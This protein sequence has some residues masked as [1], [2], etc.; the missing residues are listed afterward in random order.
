M[1][2]LKGCSNAWVVT[3]K[4]VLTVV[5]LLSGL[6]AAPANAELQWVAR[7]ADVDVPVTSGRVDVDFVFTNLGAAPVAL[8]K[9]SASCSC[10]T[11]ALPK[12]VYQPGEKGTLSVSVL[13]DSRDGPESRKVLVQ[14]DAQDDGGTVLKINVR[15]PSIA[16][17]EPPVLEWRQG[18]PEYRVVLV[19]VLQKPCRV[20]RVKSPASQECELVTVKE[21]EVYRVFAK[22]PGSIPL[23]DVVL[24]TDCITD[25]G[26]SKAIR[27]QQTRAPSTAKR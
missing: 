16:T 12:R 8:K 19:R 15:S 21:G 24:D 3:M 10:V 11:T 1:A 27:I 2:G 7:E 17:C 26:V 20:L 9:V 14:T 4:I 13:R 6:A 25:A 22:R 5:A 18:D 23:D